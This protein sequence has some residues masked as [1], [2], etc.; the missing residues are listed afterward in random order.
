MLLRLFVLE[1]SH[2]FT[3]EFGRLFVLEL[4]SMLML[5]FGLLLSK[6]LSCSFC[7]SCGYFPP[8]LLFCLCLGNRP[9]VVRMA[10]LAR[11]GRRCIGGRMSPVDRPL[12]F[13]IGEH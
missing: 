7:G 12:E 1:S 3:L 9:C 8:L 2:L 5:E 4:F 13:G 11:S 6:S 10:F